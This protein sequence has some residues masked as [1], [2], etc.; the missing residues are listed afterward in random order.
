MYKKITKYYHSKERRMKSE[1]FIL[2]IKYFKKIKDMN[3]S[4]NVFILNNVASEVKIT[5]HSKTIHL[6]ECHKK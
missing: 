6:Y 5:F 2:K 3:T 1:K 4:Q